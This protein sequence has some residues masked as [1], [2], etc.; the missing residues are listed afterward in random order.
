MT[1]LLYCL[2]LLLIAPE[3]LAGPFTPPPTD[4]SVNLLGVIFGSNIGSI[5]LGG[6]PNPV[7][8]DIMEKFNFIIVVTGT[9]IVSYAGILSVI[10][11]AHEGTPM[12]KNWSAIWI[13]MRSVAGMALM[14]PAPASGYSMIQ[15]TV[16]WI[17]IQ[18]IGAADS[19]WN[20][21]L[22]GLAQGVSVSAGTQVTDPTLYKT[23]QD[24][25]QSLLNAQTCMSGVYRQ[26]TTNTENANANNGNGNWMSH[27]GA[28]VTNFAKVK[29]TDDPIIGDAFPV[30]RCTSGDRYAQMRGTSYFGVNDPSDP[31]G[32]VI[33][34]SL[35]VVGTACTSD[36]TIGNT[37]QHPS[38]ADL[39]DAAKKIYYTKLNAI[40]NMLTALQPISQGLA[41]GTYAERLSTGDTSTNVPPPGAVN[42]A[43]TAYQN[44]MSS[45]VIPTLGN[46]VSGPGIGDITDL[47]STITKGEENGWISAGAFY[48][49]FNQTLTASK[50]FPSASKFDAIKDSVYASCDPTSQ[51]CGDPSIP[52]CCGP[53]CKTTGFS[54]GYGGNL[55]S[56]GVTPKDMK[57]I[58]T[59]L[60]MS[61]VYYTEDVTKKSTS[62]FSTQGGQGSGTAN[63][64]LSAASSY[65]AQ[66]ATDMENLFQNNTGDPLINQAVF[67]NKIMVGIETSFFAVV[68]LALITALLVPIPD[69]E[70][71]IQGP[72]LGDYAAVMV[73]VI[74]AIYALLLPLF[75]VMW[76]MGAMLAVYVP[77]IPFMM[78]TMG[79]LG[80]MLTVVEAI[81]A[82][83]IIALGVV[84]PAADELGKLTHALQI[85][86]NI[87]LR[88][89][90]MI[91]GFILAGRVYKAIVVLINFGMGAVFNTVA[92]SMSVHSMFSTFVVISVYTTFIIA[93]TNTSFS[94]INAVP[95]KILRWIGGGP[96]H[97]ETGA[98]GEA[99]GAAE[100][101]SQAVGKGMEEIGGK[102]GGA[103]SAGALRGANK[104]AGLKKG[105]DKL[106]VNKKDE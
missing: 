100:K 102:A 27:N 64:A 18:G 4:Q 8:A 44:M 79:A 36:F 15:V 10:N 90:L 43:A 32:M 83:P 30:G 3:L 6:Q 12:G 47:Q 55:S 53:D 81:I 72:R 71:G 106:G 103:G 77:L 28:L 7:L 101:T 38:D 96:E 68:T 50:I 61:C 93:I 66:A 69:E 20:I 98:V 51:T 48:F 92:G 70:A 45:L 33:C 59:D 40:S 52:Q 37:P 17:I 104:F 25:A 91:F 74:L 14:V 76:A 99:K 35:N 86:A 89:M 82:G 75:A 67:G 31:T 78:F 5:P 62:L 49:V 73:L 63:E 16:M 95:D 85:L 13:P 11:T 58:A 87:F 46:N 34:G 57:A 84:V 9:I 60:G 29:T 105:L 24:L 42:Q 19:L 88:P 21:A 2:L 1:Q 22:D 56:N 65:N 26:A 39:K 41:D 94:L 80:W 54:E 97:T 23:G